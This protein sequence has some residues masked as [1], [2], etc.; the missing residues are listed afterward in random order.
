MSRV[1][2]SLLRYA[3]TAMSL[4]ALV[5]CGSLISSAKKEFAEDLSAT[6]LS[7]DEPETIRQ[8]LP[9]YLVLVSS[10]IRSD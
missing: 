8:A 2:F 9:T 10:L 7:Y 6:I 1:V 5:S 3:L 4:L